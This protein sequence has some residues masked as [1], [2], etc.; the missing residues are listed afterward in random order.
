[1]SLTTFILL[2][3]EKVGFKMKSTQLLQDN[4]QHDVFEGESIHLGEVLSLASNGNL[5]FSKDINQFSNHYSGLCQ[6]GQRKH[7]S[8]RFLLII[9]KFLLNQEIDILL[10]CMICFS[11]ILGRILKNLYKLD[12]VLITLMFRLI[13]R[14]S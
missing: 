2:V 8:G 5:I 3:L 10:N 1:M 9:F 4:D 14:Y 7:S 6:I 12:L 11:K 13:L